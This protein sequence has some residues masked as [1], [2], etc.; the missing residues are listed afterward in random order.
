MSS[1]ILSPLQL[2]SA[3]MNKRT[4]NLLGVLSLAVA[5][6][7]ENSFQ[8][9]LKHTGETPAALIVIGYGLGP[10]ND[11]LRRVLGLSHSG[12][13]RLVD[14]L[15]NDGLVE[16]RAG[17]DMR[18]ISLYVT[19]RGKAL[20]E[21]LLK[22]RLTSINPLLE[23]LTTEEQALLGEL[24]YKVLSSLETTDMERRN[25]C[26]LCDKRVCNECPIPA[27]L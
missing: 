10:T 5:S 7:I 6:R 18:E 11:R 16:R 15:V 21:R 3:S 27:D 26:R 4:S 1:C 8:D 22:R 24:L 9:L 14:R 19:K 13:V 2:S 23:T 20:R 25:L 12:T 17:R